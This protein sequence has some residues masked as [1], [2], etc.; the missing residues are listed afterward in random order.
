MTFMFYW[1]VISSGLAFICLAW[2][3]WNRDL[4]AGAGW[5]MA[6]FGYAA[7]AITHIHAG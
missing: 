5:W 1:D 3:I 7:L 4:F 6:T 2:S